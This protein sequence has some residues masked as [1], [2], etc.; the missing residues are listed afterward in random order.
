VPP[1]ISSTIDRALVD[2]KARAHRGCH[3]FG[4][5]VHATGARAFGGLLDRAALDLGRAERYADQDARR[6]AE[7]AVAVHLADE[8]LEHPLRV[9]EVGDDAVLHRPHGGDVARR[10][11]EHPFRFGADGHD[12]LAAASRFVLHRDHRGFVQD[13]ALAADV[14][15]RIRRAEV[16][17]DVA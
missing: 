11:S 7:P 16:D 6:G 9:G 17:R 13:D 8:V 5:H 2:R 1:P 14:D 3:R 12:D 15:E 4:Y 10:A